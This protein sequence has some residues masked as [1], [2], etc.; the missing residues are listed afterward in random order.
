MPNMKFIIL[1]ILIFSLIPSLAYSGKLYKWVDQDG[2]VHV[3]DKPETVPREL[4][5][6]TEL[7]PKSN[8]DR[9]IATVKDLWSQTNPQKH[10][11][12]SGIGIII[13]IL[14][15]YR[16]IPYTRHKLGE[17]RRADALRALVLSGIDDMNPIEFTD[18]I[19]KLLESRGFKVQ[20]PDSSLNRGVHVIAEKNKLKYAVQ[21]EQQS[22][23]VSRPVLN[24]LEREK[25][26]YGCERAILITRSYFTEDAAEF[27]KSTACDLI[28]R[29]TLSNWIRDFEKRRG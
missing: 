29:D 19:V 12:A 25:H 17:R 6:A 15:A 3:T 2:V 16:L 10:L 22:C 23:S 5:T 20:T 27:A 1:T 9:S 21:V 4:R 8:I 14:V 7:S 26:R 13:L 24:N 18:Y 11:M 28:D